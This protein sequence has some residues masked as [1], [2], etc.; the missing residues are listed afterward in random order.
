MNVGQLNLALMAETKD[1][2]MYPGWDKRERDYLKCSM[3]GLAFS[4]LCVGRVVFKYGDRVVTIN[5]CL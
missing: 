1:A 3:S 4:A 5:F 2:G